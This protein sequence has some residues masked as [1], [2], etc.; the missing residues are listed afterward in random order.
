MIDYTIMPRPINSNKK[1]E[2]QYFKSSFNLV[3]D[4]NLKNKQELS[5][6]SL[7]SE[8]N[9]LK[10]LQSLFQIGKNSNQKKQLLKSVSDKKKALSQQIQ[11]LNKLFKNTQKRLTY[12]SV[13]LDSTII[14]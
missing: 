12:N 3:R 8:L 5:L 7:K 14:E 11:I 6:N 1:K 9:E 13:K 10:D 4:L 2:E